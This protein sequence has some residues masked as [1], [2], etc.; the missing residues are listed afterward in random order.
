MSNYGNFEEL[1]KFRDDILRKL[2]QNPIIIQALT[3]NDEDFCKIVTPERLEEL[4]KAKDVKSK[5]ELLKIQ[6][7]LTQMGNDLLYTKIFP[8]R[9]RCNADDQSATYITFGCNTSQ[10]ETLLPYKN[11]TLKTISIYFDIYCKYD[12]VKVTMNDETKLRFDCILIEIDKMFNKQKL[13]GSFNGLKLIGHGDL[14][15]YEGRWHGCQVGYKIEGLNVPYRGLLNADKTIIPEEV[16]EPE[17]DTET[18]NED[19]TAPEEGGAEID[20]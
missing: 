12:L 1:P 19:I 13:D 14:S 18:P 11:K 10:N 9:Y 5:R 6:S 17:G 20:G 2:S 8:Y 15:I 4:Q 16:E 7:S 3:Y